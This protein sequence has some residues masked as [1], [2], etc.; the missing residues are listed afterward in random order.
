MVDTS[1]AKTSRKQ[2]YTREHAITSANPWLDY[3]PSVYGGEIRLLSRDELLR[4]ISGDVSVAM[5]AY[6]DLATDSHCYAVLN[7]QFSEITSRK[8]VIK[9]ARPGNPKDEEAAEFIK[10]QISL[11]EINYEDFLEDSEG[12]KAILSG[13]TGF[14]GLCRTLLMA[15]LTGIQPVEV[16]YKRNEETN[17]IEVDYIKSR[18]IRLFAFDEDGEG[19]IIP[20]MRTRQNSLY[21]EPIKPRKFIFHRH[22]AIQNS[23]PLGL[24]LGRFLYYPVQWKREALSYH[25]GVL[26]NHVDP[27]AVGTYPTNATTEQINEFFNAIK[28]LGRKSRLVVREGFSVDFMDSAALGNADTLTKLVDYCDM[29]IS[30]AVLGEATTGEQLGGSEARDRVSQ[31]IRLQMAKSWSDSLNAT[32]RNTLFKWL[33]EWN[34]GPDA[35]P[36]IIERNWDSIDDILSIATT[37]SQIGYQVDRDYLQEVTGVPIAE[38]VQDD[39]EIVEPAI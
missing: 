21:G 25:L 12:P 36:P 38:E 2:S 22:W 7:K 11:L 17:Q 3:M 34:F 10:Q 20:K 4:G 9:P 16:I 13:T 6:L 29:Q 5:E 14:D 31:S 24:G 39:A 26:E 1:V 18:D 33:V 8:Y 28:N 30:L 23:D 15:V 35:E 32:I 19:N 27:S 37:Y